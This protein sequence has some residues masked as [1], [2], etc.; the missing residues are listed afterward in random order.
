M[1][2]PALGKDPRFASASARLERRDELD[3]VVSEF[4]STRPARD[5]ES[6]LQQA[7]IAASAVLRSGESIVD[8]QLLHRG[9]F[10]PVSGPRDHATMVEAARARLSRTPACVEGE[11]PMLGLH[12]NDVLTDILGYDDERIAALAIAGALE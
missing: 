8:P 7:G 2:K 3:C 6:L 5:V 1:G 9:H 11:V 4:T 10:V 12:T